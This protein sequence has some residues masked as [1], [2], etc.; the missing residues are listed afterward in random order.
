LTATAVKPDDRH[1]RHDRHDRLGGRR[2]YRSRVR[3]GDHQLCRSFAAR[4]HDR[5]DSALGGHT[6]GYLFGEHEIS[7]LSAGW[8]SRI[9]L[10]TGLPACR[11]MHRRRAPRTHAAALRAHCHQWRTPTALPGGDDAGV[12][13]AE[14][15]SPLLSVVRALPLPVDRRAVVADAADEPL[16]ELQR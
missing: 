2:R 9:D 6:G 10:T 7:A 5:S 12:G 11:I 13:Q 16:R 15:S 8:Q 14:I 4:G 1:D 3:V